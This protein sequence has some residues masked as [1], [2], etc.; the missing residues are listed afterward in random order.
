MP[1]IIPNTFANGSTIQANQLDENINAVQ[2]YVCG[3]IVS[4]D[5]NVGF[6]TQ[7]IAKPE[8][9]P[10][11]N[12]LALIT[13]PCGGQ[14]FST[15]EASFTGICSQPSGEWDGSGTVGSNELSQETPVSV[16]KTGITFYLAD[17]ADVFFQF[18]GSPHTTAVSALKD[19]TKGGYRHTRFY[20]YIDGDKKTSTKMTAWDE[21]PKPYKSRQFMSGFYFMPSMAKGY[22]SIDIKG[23]TDTNYTLLFTWSVSMEAYY[24]FPA[25]TSVP[26]EPPD[27]PIGG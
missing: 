22:H 17:T 20:I 13:G 7:D 21:S 9:N 6:E 10:I 12:Q 5:L 27:E 23:F 14:A 18:Q 8:Y 19:A 25:G 24:Q 3:G 1:V 15:A 26:Q 11:T 2:E 4:G 16:N